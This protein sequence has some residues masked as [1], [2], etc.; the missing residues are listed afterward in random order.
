MVKRKNNNGIFYVVISLVLGIAFVATVGVSAG[1]SLNQLIA[2]AIA[3]RVAPEIVANLNLQPSEEP[4]LGASSGPEVYNNMFF[5]DQVLAGFAVNQPFNIPAT[6]TLNV[7]TG[8]RDLRASIASYTNTTGR[9]LECDLVRNAILTSSDTWIFSYGVGTTTKVDAGP[10]WAN[11]TTA[12]LIASTT[13][14]NV[15]DGTA[16]NWNL[17]TNEGNAGSFYTKNNYGSPTTTAF[18]LDNGVSIVAYIKTIDATSSD[19]FV[20]ND[21]NKLTGALQAN[22]HFFNY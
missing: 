14:T 2:L 6:S 21:G 10:S 20:R 1:A 18:V 19:S 5:Y 17:F 13:A 7:Y 4:Q 12:T 3:D 8:G 9:K 11:T 22:C 15:T 16:N